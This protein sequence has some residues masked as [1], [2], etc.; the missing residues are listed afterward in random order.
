MTLSYYS[1]LSC[2]LSYELSCLAVMVHRALV[3]LLYSCH[4]MSWALVFIHSIINSF[5]EETILTQSGL[6]KANVP[7]LSR[8]LSVSTFTFLNDRMSFLD[9]KLEQSSHY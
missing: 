9:M 8:K 5:R 3:F 1:V 2:G 7:G 6:F 4:R